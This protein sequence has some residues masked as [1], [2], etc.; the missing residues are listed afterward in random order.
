MKQYFIILIIILVGQIEGISQSCIPNGIIFETQ[1]QID[2][3]QINYPNCTEIEGDVMIGESVSGD[4]TNLN[5]LS[6]LEAIDGFLGIINN[7][8]LQNLN[9]LNNLKR[10]GVGIELVDNSSLINLEGLDSLQRIDGY[11][12]VHINN[13]LQNLYGIDALDSVYG[14]F[15]VYDNDRIQNLEGAESLQ[16]VGGMF[17][18]GF[19]DSLQ[20]L[21][22]LNNLNTLGNDLRVN[23]NPAITNLNGLE[24]LKSAGRHLIIGHNPLL[25]DI[26]ALIG[27]QSIDGYFWVNYNDVLTSL[28]GL[29]NIDPDGISEL[30]LEDNPLL[31]FCHV[32]SVCKYISGP[33]PI[34][35]AIMHNASGCNSREEVEEACLTNVNQY[36]NREQIKI[37]PNPA[38]NELFISGPFYAPVNARICNYLGEKIMEINQVTDYININT[39]KGGIYIL[40]VNYKNQTFRSSFVKQ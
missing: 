17:Y 30:T 37:F 4:I 3:F 8:A 6:Q 36:L 12:I 27:L 7:S 35:G 13:N 20:N 34:Y 22:G 10:I 11:F 31:S 23:Y 32:K 1:T 16:Y 5:G 38:H 21:S 33:P 29:D 25:E 24:N 26:S 18:I 15:K 9:G 19:N 14:E 40:E 39:L 2:S 28:Y